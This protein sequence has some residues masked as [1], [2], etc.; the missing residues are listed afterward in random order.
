[1]LADG[2]E[3]RRPPEP[4]QRASRLDGPIHQPEGASGSRCEAARSTLR[5]WRGSAGRYTIARADVPGGNARRRPGHLIHTQSLAPCH[6][7]CAESQS[8]GWAATNLTSTRRAAPGRCGPWQKEHL[9]DL[10]EIHPWKGPCGSISSSASGLTILPR[11]V[12]YLLK[13]V[14][15]CIGLSCL[16]LEPRALELQRHCS[17]LMSL[18]LGL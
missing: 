9:E 3:R 17:S 10:M 14:R 15:N 7:R 5:S 2:S 12:R 8:S 1:V 16:V 6:G 13:M 4:L 11:C 18:F